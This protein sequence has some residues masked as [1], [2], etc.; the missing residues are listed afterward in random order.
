M[1]VNELLSR[2]QGSDLSVE[3]APLRPVPVSGPVLDTYSDGSVSSP[4]QPSRSL[5]GVGVWVRGGDSDL[6]PR[7]FSEMVWEQAQEDGLE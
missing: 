1:T 7:E 4:A 3:L 2:M 6:I 5:A